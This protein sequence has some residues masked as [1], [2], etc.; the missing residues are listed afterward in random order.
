MV[1]AK[2]ARGNPSPELDLAAV[3]RVL[4]DPVRLEIV[5][6]LTDGRLRTSGQIAEHVDLPA[7]TCS[8]HLKQLL[9]A[10]ITECWSEPTPLAFYNV[11]GVGTTQLCNAQRV[12]DTAGIYLRPYIGYSPA[13]T[14]GDRPHGCTC[15]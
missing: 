14:S 11:P 10:G 5:R 13:I 4:G 1:S 7:S 9:V 8:Y 6:L 3:M 12:D 15:G 2:R